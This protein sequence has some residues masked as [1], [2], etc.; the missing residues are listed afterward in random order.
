M[1]HAKGA[2]TGIDLTKEVKCTYTH[3]H[4]YVHKYTYVRMRA[5]L[6]KTHTSTQTHAELREASKTGRAFE[7]DKLLGILKKVKA[8]HSDFQYGKDK[9]RKSGWRA[10]IVVPDVCV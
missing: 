5:Y 7:V 10:V 2:K 6:I 1:L 9:V 8:N 4:T 3:A